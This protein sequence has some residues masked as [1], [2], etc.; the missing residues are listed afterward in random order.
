MKRIGLLGGMSWESTATYYKLLNQGARER[1]GGLHSA[2]IL[3]ASFDFAE[4]E[5]LMRVGD[6]EAVGRLMTREACRLEGAG[7]QLLGIATNTVHKVA[8]AVEA[9]LTAPF[10]HIADAVGRE[11]AAMGVKRAGLL[12]SRFTMEEDFY[13]ARVKSRHGVDLVVPEAEDRAEVD[14]VIFEELVRGR[15]LETSRAAYARIMSDLA[16]RGCGAVVLGCT[17][18]GLL[19]AEGDSPVPMLDTTALHAEAL[20]D[21]AL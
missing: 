18:I 20:L 14:R 9:A 10:V 17:E 19:V 5:A 7:A 3:L 4:V 13:R 15:L 6:W 16:G 8:D 2:D 21:A 11:L 1:L 12:G